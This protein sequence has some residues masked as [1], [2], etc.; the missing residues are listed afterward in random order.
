MIQM[1]G[2]GLRGTKV[3]GGT[4]ETYIVS[5][6]DEWAEKI[7]WASPEHLFIEENVDFHDARPQTKE[8]LIRLISLDKIE[9][10]A[11]L[12]DESINTRGL[13]SLPFIQRVPVGVYAFSLLPDGEESREL[14]CDVLV[15]DST[16]DAFAA[17]TNDLPQFLEVHGCGKNAKSDWLDESALDELGMRA[18][19]EYFLGVDPIPG[20]WIEDFRNMIQYCFVYGARPDFIPFTQRDQFDV[21]RVAAEIFAKGLG[22]RRKVDFI[23]SLWKDTS[24][25]WQVFFG[26]NQRYFVRE[27]SLA[28]ERLEFPP[29]PISGSRPTIVHPERPLGEFSMSELRESHPKYA[30]ELREEVFR[31]AKTKTGEFQCAISKKTSPYRIDFEIDHRIPR[32]EGGLTTL[33]NLQLAFRKENRRKGTK[34]A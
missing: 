13:E 14:P 8:Q 34:L 25:A 19:E 5:F 12:L 18:E 3:K 9:E 29:P 1:I 11:R 33:D 2:R 28:L 10:F 21:D 22:G 23:E 17:F 31:R 26:Y 7:E 16:H 30:R 24:S 27:I 20:Y 32:A 15:Y 6:I 4:K